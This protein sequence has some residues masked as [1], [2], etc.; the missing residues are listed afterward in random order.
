M[1]RL[2]VE[3]IKKGL[4]QA[5]LARMAGVHPSVI[6]RLERGFLPPYAGWRKRIAKALEWPARRAY[7]LFEKVEEEGEE[8]FGH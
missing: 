3:R 5:E 6:S 2:K 4:S 8:Y 7:E 1:Y